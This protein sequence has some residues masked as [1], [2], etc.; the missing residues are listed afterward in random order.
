MMKTKLQLFILCVHVFLL[1]L[2]VN[3]AAQTFPGLNRP[4]KDQELFCKSL[5]FEDKLTPER[6]V[7]PRSELDAFSK[8]LANVPIGILP[9]VLNSFHQIVTELLALG[10]SG[11]EITGIL[12]GNANFPLW[13]QSLSPWGRPEMESEVNLSRWIPAEKLATE[14]SSIRQAW[15]SPS[16]NYILVQSEDELVLFD[17]N[18]KFIKQY[19][20]KDLDIYSAA[21]FSDE[22]GLYLTAVQL[23]ESRAILKAFDL[24][25]EEKEHIPITQYLEDVMALSRSENTLTIQALSINPVNAAFRIRLIAS[26]DLFKA[27]S[28]TQELKGMQIPCSNNKN[29]KRNLLGDI[30]YRIPMYSR[31]IGAV[32]FYDSN[33]Q[34]AQAFKGAHHDDSN[35]EFRPNYIERSPDHRRI[36]VFEETTNSLF[37]WKS[38][39]ERTFFPLGRNSFL[40]DVYFT[41]DGFLAVT[42]DEK[43]AANNKNHIRIWDQTG[44][45]IGVFPFSTEA[46]TVDAQFIENGKL[47]IISA[48]PLLP[49]VIS[50]EGRLMEVLSRGDFLNG[51]TKFSVSPD[52]GRIITFSRKDAQIWMPNTLNR[53]Q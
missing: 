26:N 6:L 41:N 50:P 49:R 53:V 18:G 32:L 31:E 10:I 13:S 9:A 39:A 43:A 52:G 14:L 17:G 16:G 37:Y 48:P 19:Q 12:R 33:G 40:Q 35:L 15:F 4:Q 44:K 42:L 20:N 51:N 45:Q 1:V 11:D 29:L 3:T 25:F 24:S 2:A 47:L 30:D 7:E 21:F 38:S 5:F 27:S 28:F 36:V 23:S 22:N 46:T 34:L 8:Q